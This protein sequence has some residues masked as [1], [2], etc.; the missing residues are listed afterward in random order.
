MEVQ[1]R[2]ADGT[3]PADDPESVDAYGHPAFP[4]DIPPPQQQ[5]Q[6]GRSKKQAANGTAAGGG[7]GGGGDWQ[8]GGCSDVADY[9]YKFATT[10]VDAR[11]REKN[12]PRH[13]T[14]LKHALM[15][16]QNSQAGRLVRVYAT[17]CNCTQPQHH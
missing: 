17:R 12:Y 8:W 15:N 7:G 11:Q 5:Q 6:S 13:S 10:F 9:G 1:Q 4:F 14:A 16:L 3:L 2:K